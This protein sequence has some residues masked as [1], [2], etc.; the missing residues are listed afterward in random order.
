MGKKQT[1]NRMED[2]N[3]NPNEIDN[4]NEGE[5]PFKDGTDICQQLMDRYSKSSAPQHRHL[6]ATAVAMRSILSAES[7]PLSPPAYFAAAI[8][9]LDDDS[10]TTLDAMAIGALLTF[11]SIVVTVVPKGGI[12]SWKAKEAVEVVVRVAGKEGLGVASLRSGVKCLGV[13][14]VG[15]CDLED[16]DSVRFGLETLLGFAIDKRPK[17]LLSLSTSTFRSGD[18]P[19]NISKRFISLSNPHL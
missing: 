2:D 13:L 12:A 18:V 8:S 1:L 10:S 6:L 3:G 7:L 17:V 15:F 19:K 5:A 14:M 4:E 16:W 9:S 11:L